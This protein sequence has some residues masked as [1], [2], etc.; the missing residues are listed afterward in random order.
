VLLNLLLN[1]ADAMGGRGR[2]A[3]EARV[4]GELVELRVSDSGRGVAAGDRAQIFDPFFTTKEPGQG[5]G[6]GLS[7][8]RSIVEAYGGTLTLSPSTEAGATFVMRLPIFRG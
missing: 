7:I 8:S 6:L 1:A 2:V 5:T 3:I 4:D